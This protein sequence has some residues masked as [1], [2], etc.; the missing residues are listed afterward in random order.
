M[1]D[2]SHSRGAFTLIELLVVIAIISVLVALLMPAMSKARIAARNVACQAKLQQLALASGMYNA[3]HREH[4][5]GA[6]WNA[7]NSTTPATVVP[8]HYGPAAS[9]PFRSQTRR[10]QSQDSLSYMGYVN[11]EKPWQCPRL[12][13]QRISPPANGRYAYHYA[14]TYLHGHYSIGKDNA[15]Y[16]SSVG[17]RQTFEIPRPHI[18]WLLFDAALEHDTRTSYL[19]LILPESWSTASDNHTPGNLPRTTGIRKYRMTHDM[20]L[21]V[22][23]WDG[24]VAFHSYENWKLEP[25]ITH[26]TNEHRN[27]MATHLSLSGKFPG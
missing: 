7:I 6:S 25:G 2:V 20:G 16:K 18:T 22:V 19:G 15:T 24:H 14:T 26:A 8:E 1:A 23:Y 4:P 3:D 21:N 27:R 9:R 10:I 17:P 5:M 11:G 13:T 12:D